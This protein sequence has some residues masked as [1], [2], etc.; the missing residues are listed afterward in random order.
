MRHSTGGNR[1]GQG[2]HH[3]ILPHQIIEGLWTVFS[4]QNLVTHNRKR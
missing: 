2:L 3:M 4:G 1:I